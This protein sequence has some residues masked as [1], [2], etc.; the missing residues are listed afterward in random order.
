MSSPTDGYWFSN[1]RFVTL[2]KP[3]PAEHYLISQAVPVTGEEVPI[4]MS[5]AVLRN[6]HEAMR[7]SIAE[8]WR[9]LVAGQLDAF[10]SEFAPF[11]RVLRSH[12]AVEDDAVFPFL[13]ALSGGQITSEHLQ[14]EHPA[15]CNWLCMCVCVYVCWCLL[16]FVRV[17]SCLLCVVSC[18]M[19]RRSNANHRASIAC[20]H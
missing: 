10:R 9:L 2:R 5:F 7:A 12:T 6:L 8:C 16:V 4:P 14:D 13:D 18:G 19:L 20:G 15:G 1:G 3:G 11:S 17:C